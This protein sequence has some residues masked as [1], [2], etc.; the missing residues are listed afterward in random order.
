M[1]NQAV[2]MLP[3]QHTFDEKSLRTK[4]CQVTA[5]LV[6]ISVLALALLACRSPDRSG[7]IELSQCFVDASTDPCASG[8]GASDE[9]H[10]RLLTEA[11][12]ELPERGC[13]GRRWE[14]PAGHTPLVATRQS[15]GQPFSLTVSAGT[16]PAFNQ[17]EEPPATDVRVEV[18]PIRAGG[19]P[20]A[21][22]QEIRGLD[23]TPIGAEGQWPTRYLGRSPIDGRDYV[24]LVPNDDNDYFV[25]CEKG[26]DGAAMNYR[27]YCQVTALLPPINTFIYWVSPE[28]LDVVGQT[29]DSISRQLHQFSK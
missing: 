7:V 16:T 27:G 29:N 11:L 12:V 20:S 4:I 21:L 15:F 10:C 3:K 2:G 19:I 18:F 23:A 14:I 28:S 9:A 17:D 6:V 26:A 8:G 1:S 25:R 22:A 13:K 5:R 24:L